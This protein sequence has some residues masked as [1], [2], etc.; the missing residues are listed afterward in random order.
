[1]IA[2]AWLPRPGGAGAAGRHLS[3]V[4][5]AR[6]EAAAITSTVAKNVS[7]P[8]TIR[9]SSGA[10]PRLSRPPQQA[11]TRLRPRYPARTPRSHSRPARAAA[12]LARGLLGPKT[13]AAHFCN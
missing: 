13:G 12:S 10:E 9:V 4:Y 5:Q 7:R 11:A 2:L 3:A 1:M 6:P 8:L